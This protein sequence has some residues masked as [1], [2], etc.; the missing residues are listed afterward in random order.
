MSLRKDI[1]RRLAEAMN[2][3]RPADAERHF[4]DSFVLHDPNQPNWPRG[5]EGARQMI[6]SFLDFA[7]DARLDILDLVEEGERVAVR[8]RVTGSRGGVALVGSI[9]AIYRFE[10]A[11]IAEDWGTSARADWDDA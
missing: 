3:R 2:E 11:L 6:R 1:L 10:G 9:V 7:P 5:R 8:W 4:A